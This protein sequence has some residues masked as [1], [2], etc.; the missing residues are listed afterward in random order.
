MNYPKSIASKF[1][2][3]ECERMVFLEK[4][5]CAVSKR[6]KIDVGY[7]EMAAVCCTG[8]NYL[9]QVKVDFL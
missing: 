6:E 3:P 8:S 1:H 9:I 5:Q 4:N 7:T 2:G